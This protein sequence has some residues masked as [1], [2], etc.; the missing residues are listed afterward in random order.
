[1]HVLHRCCARFIVKH[2]KHVPE[3]LGSSCRTTVTNQKKHYP[4]SMAFWL[5]GF[6]D[7]SLFQH[8]NRIHPKSLPYAM[9]ESDFSGNMNNTLDFA[10][11]IYIKPGFNRVQFPLAFTAPW[12]VWTSMRSVY[13]GF[14]VHR[15]VGPGLCFCDAGNGDHCTR[16][17]GAVELDISVYLR[18]G[19]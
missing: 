15:P 5:D 18:W 1:M 13:S 4:V 9:C 6:I 14:S 10:S 17:F 2:I 8:I 12:H 7:P 3:I 11:P 16:S 19:L